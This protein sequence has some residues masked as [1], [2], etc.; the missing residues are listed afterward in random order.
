M[1][2]DALN[3][4]VQRYHLFMR[5]LLGEICGVG[6]DV[7][8]VMQCST[9]IVVWL[10]KRQGHFLF[11][12]IPFTYHELTKGWNAQLAKVFTPSSCELTDMFSPLLSFPCDQW[13]LSFRGLR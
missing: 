3:Y 2:N 10:S 1:K 5:M 13:L 6:G 12:V 7:W 4:T 9:V 11:K 8:W